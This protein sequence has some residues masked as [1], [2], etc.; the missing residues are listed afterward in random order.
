MNDGIEILLYD[1]RRKP[2]D[3]TEVIGPTQCAVLLKGHKSS[4]PLSPAGQPF[5]KREDATCLLF[6]RLDTAQKFCEAKVLALPHVSCE[7]L[8]AQ[9]RA[10]PPLMVI[11]HP[12]YVNDNDYGSSWSRRRKLIAVCLLLISGP[13]FWLD[14]RRQAT[15]ILPT[16]LGFNC[17]LLA[18]RFLYWDFG[19]RHREQERLK[20]VEAHRRLELGDA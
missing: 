16:F 8:N 15:L 1:R 20:R 3:W 10:L 14:W 19:A 5:A 12:D 2:S 11:T 6:D 13:L 9:G 7:I 17:I 18:M 4:V